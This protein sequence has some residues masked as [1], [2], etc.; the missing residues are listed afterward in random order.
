MLRITAVRG[1]LVLPTVRVENCK[2]DGLT[3]KAGADSCDIFAIKTSS[4]PLL[5]L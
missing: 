3:V 5:L 1:L 4:C 2:R